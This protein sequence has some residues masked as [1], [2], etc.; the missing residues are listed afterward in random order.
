MFNTYITRS[1]DE[2]GNMKWNTMKILK[3]N[4]V[5]YTTY[6]QEV[7]ER[8]GYSFMGT[9]RESEY[10][11]YY[12]EDYIEE[13]YSDPEN[14]NKEPDESMMLK[15]PYD[16]AVHRKDVNIDALID[17][18]LFA[19]PSNTPAVIYP[20]SMLDAV[21][22]D[23]FFYETDY[24]FMAEDHRAA[25]DDMEKLLVANGMDTS[26]LRDE[27]E[28]KEAI[29]MMVLVVN[30]FS[31]G[32][33]ILISLIALANV[34][35]TISTN[36]SLRRREFAM[37]KSIGLADR[38]FRKMMSYE[39]LIYGVKGLAWGLPAAVVLTYVIYRVTSS[40]LTS[41]FYLPWYSVAIAVGSVFLVVFATMIYATG[42]IKKDNPIDALKNE[43]L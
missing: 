33:I 41:R 22:E 4:T 36:V 23:D 1:M 21:V 17:E 19:M 8:E 11:M 39:C 3:D 26:R 10:A 15:V 31:Y 12:P 35:N 20:Y 13:F 43:N 9:D 14:Y 6:F 38:G 27:G 29:K 18:T 25:Y 16:E 37:L 42:K 30:V 40:A 7:Q 28:N 34:F 5:P 32:F 2:E 24:Y